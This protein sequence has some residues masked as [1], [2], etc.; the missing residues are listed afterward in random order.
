MK[1]TTAAQRILALSAF[2]GYSLPSGTRVEGLPAHFIRFPNGDGYAVVTMDEACTTSYGFDDGR[3]AT[4]AD[5][6]KVGRETFIVFPYLR[7]TEETPADVTPAALARLL[8]RFLDNAQGDGEVNDLALALGDMAA[9]A[10]P[11]GAAIKV[12]YL[13][14]LVTAVAQ[15]GE[16]AA[17][18]VIEEAEDADAARTYRGLKRLLTANAKRAGKAGRDIL[19]QVPN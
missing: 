12:A 2:L 8:F 9:N 18:G 17:D 5:C 13:N 4:D 3:D 16:V 14:Q 19:D 10:C 11:Q 7:T 6:I 15:G 1:P